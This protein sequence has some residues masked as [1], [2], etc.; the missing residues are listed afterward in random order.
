MGEGL[1]I[2]RLDYLKAWFD[3]I[4]ARPATQKALTIPKPFPAFFGKGDESKSE[5]ENA[6][7]F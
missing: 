2:D 5:K 7:R 6:A 3:R 4:D 1:A